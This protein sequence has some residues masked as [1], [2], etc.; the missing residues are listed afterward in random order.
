MA[1][2]LPDDRGVGAAIGEVGAEGV[3][4]DVRGATVL[5]QPG[6]LGVA[7]HDPGDVAGAQRWWRLAGAR[8]RQQQVLG[9]GRRAA[10]DPGG[11]RGERVLVEWDRSGAAALAV[12]DRHPPAGRSGDCCAQ[13]RV[14]CSLALIDV[15]DQQVGG[16]AAPETG[17]AEQVQQRQVALALAGAP[18]G[19]PQQ[20][21]ELLFRE[22]ARLAAGDALRADGP[23][24]RVEIPA[25]GSVIAIARS[26][27]RCG[28]SSNKPFCDGTHAVIDFDGTLAN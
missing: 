26:I 11:D 19:H 28:G 10:F 25:E 13:A 3:A 6:G 27:C 4:Q 1:G 18:V 17:R 16:L 2:E 20:S 12:A 8:Q 5:R 22:G 9:R 15:G 23:D 24:R 14:A 7:G 21:L